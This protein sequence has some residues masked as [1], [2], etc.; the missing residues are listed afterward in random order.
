MKIS[1]LEV[2]REYIPTS[3]PDNAANADSNK[4]LP[5]IAPEDTRLTIE[6]GLTVP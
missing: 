1:S 4:D 6:Q 3:S 2:A 5:G